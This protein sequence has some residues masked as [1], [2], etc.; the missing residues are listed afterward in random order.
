MLSTYNCNDID[1]N[2]TTNKYSNT[3]KSK[4]QAD[5]VVQVRMVY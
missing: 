1:T 4:T 2:G 5:S 3:V